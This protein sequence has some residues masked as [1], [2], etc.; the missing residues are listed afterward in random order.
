M[1]ITRTNESESNNITSE[2]LKDFAN[3][4]V[5][6]SNFIDRIKERKDIRTK[7][8][9]ATI[10]DKMADIKE[11]IG[12]SSG[13]HNENIKTAGSSECQHDYAC[14]CPPPCDCEENNCEVCFPEENS[15]NY[16]KIE[17]R[18]LDEIERDVF[19]IKAMLKYIIEIISKDGH[20]STPQILSIVRREPGHTTAL[21][22]VCPDKLKS[23]IESKIPKKNSAPASYIGSGEWADFGYDGDGDQEKDY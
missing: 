21:N 23:F 11:R 1:R 12:Y 15:D 19:S 20:M 18:Q 17:D 4:I 5:K 10:E 6:E 7:E 2:W 8:T 3:D 13:N 14:D 22:R 16:G 9:F